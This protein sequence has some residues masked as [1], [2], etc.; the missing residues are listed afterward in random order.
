MFKQGRIIQGAKGAI[1]QGHHKIGGTTLADCR[2]DIL[3]AYI[4]FL[5]GT[6]IYGPIILINLTWQGFPLLWGRGTPPPPIKGSS[7]PIKGWSLPPPKS[8]KFCATPIEN[9]ALII[10]HQAL[11]LPTEA[12]PP[13][14]TEFPHIKIRIENPGLIRR[15]RGG[16]KDI[17]PP[18][19]LLV[20]CRETKLPNVDIL[21]HS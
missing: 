16:L 2:M 12:P 4:I 8:G 21:E 3:V 15:R 17:R 13:L 20:A 7:L 18:P 19:Y 11:I 5:K 9:F 1:A 6:Y 10:P 14:W